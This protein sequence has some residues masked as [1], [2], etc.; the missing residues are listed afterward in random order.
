MY[1]KLKTVHYDLRFAPS[2]YIRTFERRLQFGK[3]FIYSSNNR[4]PSIDR[5]HGVRF[6]GTNRKEREKEDRQPD[7]LT[8]RRAGRQTDRQTD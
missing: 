5:G 6:V 3:S 8:D 2:A 7:R 4:G 1:N